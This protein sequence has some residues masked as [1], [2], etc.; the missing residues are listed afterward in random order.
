MKAILKNPSFRVI[1]KE[2]AGAVEEKANPYQFGVRF[3]DVLCE[4]RPLKGYPGLRECCGAFAAEIQALEWPELRRTLLKC[5]PASLS[6]SFLLKGA[7]AFYKGFREKVVGDTIEYARMVK[8]V[9]KA[10]N[11][12]CTVHPGIAPFLDRF[13]EKWQEK[14]PKKR[15]VSW[16]SRPSRRREVMG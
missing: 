2:W 5:L 15:G 10:G 11:L 3:L 14:R 6:T 7:G 8:G 4:P 9:K 13:P 16:P 1:L 12:S